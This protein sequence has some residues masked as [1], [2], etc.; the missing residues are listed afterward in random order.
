V[1]FLS[2]LLVNLQYTDFNGTAQV[3]QLSI[4]FS[5][6]LNWTVWLHLG[7]VH[8]SRHQQ[9]LDQKLRDKLQLV[10]LISRLLLDSFSSSAK[11]PRKTPREINTI[12]ARGGRGRHVA[13]SWLDSLFPNYSC[14]SGKPL[15]HG[16]CILRTSH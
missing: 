16:Y 3:L 13:S 8:R 14:I 4:C 12:K 9:E 2:I 10:I 1:K 11:L 6:L 15:P 7:C 5:V